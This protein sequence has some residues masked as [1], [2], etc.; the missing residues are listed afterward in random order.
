M[1]SNDGHAQA[2]QHHKAHSSSITRQKNGI[3]KSTEL[4]SEMPSAV[5]TVFP[6]CAVRTY[7][8]TH[9]EV[10]LLPL[11]IPS[12]ISTLIVPN[13]IISLVLSASP[14][15]SLPFLFSSLSS[16]VFQPPPALRALSPVSL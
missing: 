16:A 9:D 4:A 3:H 6:K 7:Q 13:Y 14:S 5:S 12:H 11:F 8:V 1:L 2:W 15:S 10:L